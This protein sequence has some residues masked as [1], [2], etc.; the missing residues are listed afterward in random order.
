[1]DGLEEMPVSVIDISLFFIAFEKEC[2]Y[3]VSSSRMNFPLRIIDSH[4]G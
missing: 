1:M 3:Q 4:L 2:V